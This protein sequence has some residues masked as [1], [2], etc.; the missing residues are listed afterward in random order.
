MSRERGD[1]LEDVRRHYGEVAAAVA[2]QAG[3]G[4]PLG[5][6]SCCEEPTLAGEAS[7]LY[8]AATLEGL[9][10]TALAASRGC[11]DPVAKA[12]L[13]PG[14]HVLDL[15]SGGGIDAL[16]AA[17]LVGEGGRVYGLDMTEEMI[18]LARENARATGSNNVEFICGRIEDIPLPDQSVDVVISNCVINFSDDK[19]RVM[20]EARR[21]LRPGGRLVVSDIVAFGDVPS[22]LA[23]PLAAITGCRCGMQGAQAYREA[24]AEAGFARVSIE[25]KTVYTLDVLQEKAARKGHLDA[26][27]AVAGRAE[28][29]GICGSAVISAWR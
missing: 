28:V 27:A 17:K 5:R 10:D 22:E 9:P 14:E 23:A 13:A 2:R 1:G 7:R 8:A 15:G 18:E 29:D 16:I 11:G 12:Q 25:P 26:F 21:V 6:A 19:P 3:D 20:R 4:A 24:L